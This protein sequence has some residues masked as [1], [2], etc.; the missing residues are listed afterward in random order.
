MKDVTI[1]L[2]VVCDWCGDSHF[3][4]Y[5]SFHNFLEN[6]TISNRDLTDYIN[7]MVPDCRESALCCNRVLTE[8]KH[9]FIKS[10]EKRR[11]NENL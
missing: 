5:T 1:D 11:K 7:E 9:G 2:T 10:R 3:M 4:S 8:K 6:M